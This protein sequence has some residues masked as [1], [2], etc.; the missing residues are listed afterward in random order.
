MA[1][2]GTSSKRIQIDRANTAIVVAVSVAAFATAFSLVTSK[3]LMARRSYQQKVVDSRQAALDQ[4][5]ANVQSVNDLKVKYSE[6]VSRQENIIKGSSIG[7]GD[8][9]GDNARII[10]DALPSKYDFP[11]LA[12]S[13]EKILQ[14]NR[15]KITTISGTDNEEAQSGSQPSPTAETVEMPFEI[16]AEGSYANMMDLLNILGQSIRP[17]Y[18]QKLTFTASGSDKVQ[19]NVSG[20]TFYKPERTLNIKEEIIP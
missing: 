9:D 12:S 7:N 10:L 19:V 15:Y 3:S 6:F 17:I 4:L 14:Y 2:R 20:K 8:R 18:V 11:A 16:G 13:L 1:R 5:E